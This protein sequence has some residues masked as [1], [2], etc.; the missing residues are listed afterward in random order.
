MISAY[1]DG[2]PDG[3]TFD[4]DVVLVCEPVSDGV[5]LPRFRRA[6]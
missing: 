1:V 5:T 4:M 2:H 3:V 6:G